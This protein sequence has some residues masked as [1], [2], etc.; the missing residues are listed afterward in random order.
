MGRLNGIAKLKK[1]YLQWKHPSAN[2]VRKVLKSM[3]CRSLTASDALAAD[4]VSSIAHGVIHSGKRFERQQFSQFLL[5]IPMWLAFI[6]LSHAAP[7]SRT[8]LIQLEE[9]DGEKSLKVKGIDTPTIELNASSQGIVIWAG[10]YGK[11]KW[12]YLPPG[13]SWSRSRGV[14]HLQ[15]GG[16][17]PEQLY[18][19][20]GGGIDSAGSS[21]Q[22]TIQLDQLLGRTVFRGAGFLTPHDGRIF[23]G[24]I[25]IRRLPDAE[26]PEYPPATAVLR[27]GTTELARIKFAEGQKKLS[28]KE[29]PGLVEKMPN[30]L[31]GGEYTLRIDGGSESAA[32]SVEEDSD[33]RDAIRDWL[34]Q[35]S[36][37][38]TRT[39][40]L[41]LQVA[42]ET[43]LTDLKGDDDQSLA[44]FSDA[45]EVLES[46]PQEKLSA[47]LSG[48]KRRLL[49]RLSGTDSITE[50]PSID[51][52][53]IAEID[54]V[55]RL[56]DTGKWEEALAKLEEDSLADSPRARGLAALYRAVILSE[57]GQ[58][59]EDEAEPAFESAIASLSEPEKSAQR[60]ADLYRAHNNYANFLLNKA[61]DQLHNHAFQMA[62][63]GHLPVLSTLQDW[64]DAESHYIEALAHCNNDNPNQRAAVQVNIAR[65]HA[66]LGD[67]IRTLDTPVDGKRQFVAGEEAA[68]AKADAPARHVSKA[69]ENATVDPLVLAAAEEIQANLAFRGRRSEECVGHANAALRAYL[70]A[71]SLAGAEGVHRLLG[72]TSMQSNQ[73]SGNS[74]LRHFLLSHELSELLRSRI[75]TDQIGRSQA[76]FF[77][78]RA[79][80]NEKI[81][82]L[83]IAAGKPVEALKYAELAKARSLEDLLLAGGATSESGEKVEELR[84]IEEMLE[85]WPQNIAALEYFVGTEKVW[86][87]VI[88]TGGGVKVHDILGDAGSSR[89]FVADVREYLDA[90]DRTTEKIRSLLSS[91]VSSPS[92]GWQDQL[93]YQEQLSAFYKVMMPEGVIGELQKARTVI[94]VPHHILHYFPFAAL[95]TQRDERKLGVY[96]V[97]EP[98]FL[99][100]EPFDLSF[101]PSLTVW[102]LMRTR[103]DRLVTQAAAVGIVDFPPIGTSGREDLPGVENDLNNLKTVFGDKVKKVLFA[104]E[105]TKTNVM[106]LLSQPGLLLFATHGEN[107]YDDPLSSYLNLLDEK[108]N[109]YLTAR[110]I[111][112]NGSRSDLIVMS[113]C[114]SGLADRSPLPGDDLFGIQRAFLQT[115]TRTVLA[116][117]WLVSD[118]TG[119]P[120]MNRF[121][122][123]LAKG[124]PAPTALADSQRAFL[125]KG[126]RATASASVDALIAKLTLHPFYWAVYTTS[127]DDRTRFDH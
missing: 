16:D 104:E 81:I 98:R 66:L 126:R 13:G 31:P 56:T 51:S 124:E 32:F 23:D 112:E 90:T 12:H 3:N 64:I 55:K 120:I 57:S 84:T 100:D 102:G 52:T 75:H 8:V 58:G 92:P 85:E 17:E 14:A 107:E 26:A 95:V 28:Y 94:V 87:F 10:R 127:G 74:A 119:P 93:Q 101:A 35:F 27:R 88:D 122:E 21:A 63:G 5:M 114:Y 60:S 4:S 43:Y 44:C 22:M 73:E 18:A 29:V 109:D 68:F 41:Y 33:Y 105:S 108:D 96:E 118:A 36:L 99:I 15:L 61:Q 11:E 6:T 70:N 115:G 39:D 125:A 91:V 110:E 69:A 83:S 80:V 49:D 30:G 24:R 67:V 106:P 40:P 42:V 47:H 72:L 113:A 48:V 1:L 76:G 62:T 77:A 71:G 123:I 19:T 116:G 97:P 53:G 117:L 46:V 54:A 20:R 50:V 78:R 37:S 38:G 82:E 25:T 86:L 111:F 121:F 45:L 7:V 65:L 79:Y 103:P 89:E 2:G 9:E 59:S 34:D